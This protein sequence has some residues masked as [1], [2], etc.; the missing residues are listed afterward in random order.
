MVV[1]Q[2]KKSVRGERSCGGLR[3]LQAAPPFRNP[4]VA[5]SLGTAGRERT[6]PASGNALVE[7]AALLGSW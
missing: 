7:K 2:L 1:L 3:L 4:V 6:R 5:A